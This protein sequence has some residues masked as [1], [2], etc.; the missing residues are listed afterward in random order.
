MK[1]ILQPVDIGKEEAVKVLDNA[2]FSLAM[3]DKLD[4]LTLCLIAAMKLGK[5]AL[6]RE[7]SNK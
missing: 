1:P 4:N 3:A 5:E 7:I 2:M 6:E